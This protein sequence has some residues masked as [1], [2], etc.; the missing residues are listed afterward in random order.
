MKKKYLVKIEKEYDAN[1]EDEARDMFLEEAYYLAKYHAESEEVGDYTSNTFCYKCEAQF[2]SV[3][4]PV[5]EEQAK[6]SVEKSGLI[7]CEKHLKEWEKEN[8]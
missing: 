6:L 5:S 7:R 2:P 1:S 3:K 4:T 8:V